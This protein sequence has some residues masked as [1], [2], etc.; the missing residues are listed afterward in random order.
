MVLDLA[1]FAISIAML[2]MTVG[3][4]L[5]L[6][7]AGALSARTAIARHPLQ[8]RASDGARHAGVDDLAV[9]L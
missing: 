1:F 9:L 3:R 5:G 2:G 7:L 8:F 4:R 6:S